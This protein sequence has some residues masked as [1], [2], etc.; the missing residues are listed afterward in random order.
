[1]EFQ[2]EGPCDA[3]ITVELAEETSYQVF[4]DGKGI[5]EMKTNR[6]GKLSLSVE[7]DH[8]DKADIRIEKQ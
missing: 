5:G 1:M 7:L 6:G 3:Q 2:V 8:A 4:I